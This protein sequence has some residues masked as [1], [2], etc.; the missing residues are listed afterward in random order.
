MHL[1]RQEAYFAWIYSEM[2]GCLVWAP[3]WQRWNN[4][5]SQ[6]S[7]GDVYLQPGI[8]SNTQD[9]MAVLVLTCLFVKRNWD[10]V[11]LHQHRAVI[12]R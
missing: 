2:R 12:A 7:I 8:S 9:A 11:T 4:A 1:V 3:L 6:A 5:L 10:C